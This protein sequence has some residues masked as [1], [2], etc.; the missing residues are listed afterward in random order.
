MPTNAAPRLWISCFNS[1]SVYPNTRFAVSPLLLLDEEAEGFGFDGC[2]GT[3]SVCVSCSDCSTA[4]VLRIAVGHA[5]VPFSAVEKLEV[6]S[7][8]LLPVCSTRYS[9]SLFALPLE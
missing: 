7:S 9:E 8:L 1:S 3:C 6:L 2:C 5:G 4:W